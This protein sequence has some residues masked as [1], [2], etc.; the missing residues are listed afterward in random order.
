[1]DL[2]SRE[3]LLEYASNSFYIFGI[4]LGIFLGIFFPVCL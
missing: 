4:C 3:D 1:M 2:E